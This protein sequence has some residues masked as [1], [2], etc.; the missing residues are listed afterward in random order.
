MC[1][2]KETTHL[3]RTDHFRIL[4][5]A[6]YHNFKNGVEV[7]G[8]EGPV[9][10]SVDYILHVLP[11]ASS[12]KSSGGQFLTFDILHFKEE[13]LV[14]LSMNDLRVFNVQNVNIMTMKIE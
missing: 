11:Y 6:G 8:T 9:L 3:E 1:G 12:C 2:G 7:E 4:S 10:A 5:V 13:L 14:A